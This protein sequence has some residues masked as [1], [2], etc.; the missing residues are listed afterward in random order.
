MIAEET[1]IQVSSNKAGYNKRSNKYYQ[2]NVNSNYNNKNNSNN[3]K[4]N[5]DNIYYDNNFESS[6][7]LVDSDKVPENY[8]SRNFG[9]SANKQITV[10]N[11]NDGDDDDTCHYGVDTSFDIDIDG[12]YKNIPLTVNNNNS[13]SK[14]QRCTDREADFKE[15]CFL[16]KISREEELAIFERFCENCF[17]NDTMFALRIIQQNSTNIIIS[18]IVE[19]LWLQYKSLNF[20][21]SAGNEEFI[22]KKLVVYRNEP[23]SDPHITFESKKKQLS[24]AKR[25]E[26]VIINRADFSASP[27]SGTDAEFSSKYIKKIKRKK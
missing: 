26:S 2:N 9:N 14:P 6:H 18:E 4:G 8:Y 7:V 1:F 12:I 16:L 20:I 27:T 13:N 3:M 17:S 10:V 22:L 15:I 25:T 5:D 21:V 23:V 19:Y 11:A 24:R